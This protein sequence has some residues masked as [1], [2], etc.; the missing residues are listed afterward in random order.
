MLKLMR[1]SFQQLKWIL[2]ALVAIFI[3]FIFVDWG[4][5]GAGGGTGGQASYAARVNGEMISYSD[6]E[7]ALKNYEE[8]YR[9]MYGQQFTPEMAQSMG[10]PR[11]VLDS[12][13]DQRL[14]EQEARR[15]HLGATSE[16]VRKKLLTIPT[17]NPEGKFVGMELYT[18]YVTGPLGYASPAAFE[19]D[20]GREIALQ[21]MESAL[22]SSVVISSKAAE[23]EYRRMNE[24]AKIRYVLYPATRELATVSVTPAEIEQYYKTNQSKYAHGE[25]RQVRYLLA[26]ANRLRSQLTAGDADMRRHYE[27]NKESFRLQPAA[28][29]IQILIKGDPANPAA[30]AAAKAKADAILAQLRGGADFKSLAKA[31]SQDPSTATNGG[32]L[33]WMEKGQT[34]A[35]FEQAIFSLPLNTFDVVHTPEYGYHIIK[36]L[37]RREG[38][39]R[40]FEEAKPE[41]Q[42]QVTD[43][44]ARDQVRD[45]IT[46]I[47][48]QVREKK[49]KT[50]QEF[51]AKANDR[52]TSNETGWFAKGEQIPG[53]GFN[54]PLSQWVFSAKQGD[55]GDVIQ[56]QRG[57]ILPYVEGVRPAGVA[58]LAEVRA[59]VEEDAK[60]AKA[61]DAASQKLAAAMAGS[62]NVDAVAAKVGLAPSEASVNRQGQIAGLT[63]DTTS[64]VEA[65]MA[66]PIGQ[67]KGPVVTGDGAVVFQVTEQKKVTDAD[68]AQNRGSFI[69]ALRQQQSRSLRQVLVQRLRKESNV[70]VN[71]KLLQQAAN[72]AG[73]P[74]A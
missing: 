18:R 59:R 40:T 48:A 74:N 17:F 68:L 58:P 61:R 45:Q 46:A 25:Q 19:Q 44:L 36:V 2:I 21:K 41:L 23:A 14:L 24:N 38:G 65:A 11:Q 73:Q 63:G 30:D 16:E 53:L 10:L 34:V 50:V 66:T 7:R 13:I 49:P 29:V 32:D 43:Q 47:A 37:E 42:A 12:L 70:E 5:G 9:Q 69:D 4:V 57:L 20:L 64:L 35:N 55:V 6:Y 15:L 31:T 71:E 22:S 54:Q 60:A 56:T 3:L 1:D 67:T 51:T 72:T 27:S 52:V 28:H 39:Y 33:G 26:D 8:M 62:A